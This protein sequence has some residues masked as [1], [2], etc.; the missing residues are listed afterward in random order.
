MYETKRKIFP[1]IPKSLLEANVFIFQN[2]KDFVSNNEIC[3][4]DSEN[5]VRIFKISTNFSLLNS[6]KYVFADRF[7]S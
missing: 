1:K 6:P 7:F 2:K 4:V 5:R 3:S